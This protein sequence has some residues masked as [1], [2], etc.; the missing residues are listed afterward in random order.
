MYALVLQPDRYVVVD[1]FFK[2]RARAAKLKE[3][4][5]IAYAGWR[6]MIEQG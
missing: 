4:V 3:S 2:I 5:M 6:S 1:T